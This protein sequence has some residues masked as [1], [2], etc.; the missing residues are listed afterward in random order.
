MKS[1]I[2]KILKIVFYP[3]IRAHQ[4]VM[5]APIYDFDN[6]LSGYSDYSRYM[7]HDK[8]KEPVYHA[9]EGRVVL[10]RHHL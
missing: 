7:T 8:Q 4:I 1:T 2:C 6:A 5:E 10:S 9:P 3:L